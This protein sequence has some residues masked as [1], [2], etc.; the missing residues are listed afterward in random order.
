MEHLDY[1]ILLVVGMIGIG[2]GLLLLR[3]AKN[4]V[5]AITNQKNYK[6]RMSNAHQSNWS[7]DGVASC[8]RWIWLHRLV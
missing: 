6:G 5:L 8:D 4:T 1:V 7:P 3:E 2:G